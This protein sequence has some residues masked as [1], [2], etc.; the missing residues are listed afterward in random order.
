MEEEKQPR[1]SVRD[2]FADK[3]IKILESDEPLSWTKGWSG[4]NGFKAPYNGQ[5]GRKYNGIN[6]LILMLSAME[7]GW[8]DS[9]FYTFHQVSK[10]DG[11]KIRKGETATPVEYWAVYDTVE[12]KSLTIAAYQQLRRDNPDRKDEEFRLYSKTAYVF[13]AAQVEGLEPLPTAEEHIYETDQLAEEVIS[14][15]SENMGV[16]LVYGGDEAYYSPGTDTIHLPPREAFFSAGELYGTTLHELAH[17]TS[18]QPRLDRP[19]AGYHTDSEAYAVEEL[20]AE[21]SSTF[22][23]AEL[24]LEMPES[25]MQNHLAYVSSWLSQIK[26]DHNV[27]FAA[28]K[29]AD[30][31][32]DYMVDQG[33][34]EVLREKLAV[35]AQMPKKLNGVSYEIW[36]LKDT[37]ENRALLFSDFDFASQYRL[38]ESRYDRV[39]AAQAGPDDYTLDQI[40]YKFNVN[41][42]ADFKGHSLSMSDVVVLNID[43]QR[44]A[45]YCDSFGFKPVPGFCQAQ[46]QQRGKA[47]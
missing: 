12:K 20:R 29:D 11:C 33:R 5:S 23:S 34:V 44:E 38:T 18:A 13:N 36:Q 3:F 43:G 42:P 1:K 25:V 7:K 46:T 19:I 37:P 28:I 17:S 21:I 8:T 41:H 47:R 9:R 45:W 15:M 6:R 27:L 10:M 32:A 39:Y 35:A 2:E 31:I 22:V 16:P 40:Y 30:R 14:T 24:G 26:Q 4:G